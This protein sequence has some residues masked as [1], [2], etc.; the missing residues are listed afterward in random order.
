MYLLQS[1]KTARLQVLAQLDGHRIIA[2]RSENLIDLADLLLVLQI[3]GRIEVRHIVDLHLAHEIVLARI[4]HDA[5]RNDALR[6]AGIEFAS[7]STAAAAASA[8]TEATAT[9]A[10][11]IRS[12]SE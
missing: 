9:A 2:Q 6:R 5:Q 1:L 8:A 7:E 10:A 12:I 4:V 11:W 3:D